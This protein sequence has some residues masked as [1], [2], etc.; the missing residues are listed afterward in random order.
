MKPLILHASSA[1]RT[2]GHRRVIHIE[3]AAADLPFGLEWP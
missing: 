2:A 3:Y 1:V